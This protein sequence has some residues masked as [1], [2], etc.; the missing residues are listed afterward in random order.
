MSDLLNVL[1]NILPS[2]CIP[3]ES[4]SIQVPILI[5]CRPSDISIGWSFL[6][7]GWSC[8]SGIEVMTEAL[9]IAHAIITW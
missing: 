1:Q 4:S 7:V 9:V 8:A 5:H 3:L 2:H 6:P